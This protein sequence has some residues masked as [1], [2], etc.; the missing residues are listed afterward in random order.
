M[1]VSSSSAIACNNLSFSWPDGT[2]VLKGLNAAF[3]PGRTGLIGV[4]G[5]G[6]STLLRLIA[7]QLAP[8]SGSVTVSG[9]IGYLAQ[10]LTLD[11][12]ITVAALLGIAGR[13]DAIWAIENGDVRTATFDAVG[14]DW[15]IEDRA[16]AELD[17]LGL[18]R[19]RLDDTVATLSGG[20]AIMTALT[21]L[22]LRRPEVLLLDEPTNNL[23]ARA[24]RRLYAAVES[25]PGVMMIVSHDRELLGRVDQIADLFGGELR[26]YGGTLTDY[27]ARRAAEQAAAEQA[28]TTAAAQVRREKRDFTEALTKQA[29]RDRQGRQVAASGSLPHAVIDSHRKHAQESAGKSRELHQ[30]RIEAAQ[31]RLREAEDAVRDDAEIRVDLPGT[32]VPAGRTL[33]TVTGLDAPWHPAAAFRE[34]DV[35]GEEDEPEVALAGLIVRGPERIALT[36]PNGAGKTTLLRA[37]TGQAALPGVEVRR[38]GAIGYLPQRLDILD[39]SLTVEQNVHAKAPAATPN[40]VRAGLARFLFRG[41]RADQVAG[42]LS[43]GERF[44]AVLAALLLAQPPPQLLILDEPTNNL[45]MSSVRQLT[46]ALQCHRGALL[47][48]SHD[49]PFLNTLGITRWLWLDRAGRLADAEPALSGVTRRPRPR[50]GRGR[51][52]ARARRRRAPSPGQPT[53]RRGRRA[54]RRGWPW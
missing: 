51:R 29:R 23:D 35:A 14:D 50:R 26:M 48:V 46:E 52:R 8:A 22:L 45:D 15:D 6:K 27:E 5:A 21:A 30:E 10:D 38:G 32:A 28:V 54:G 33:L 40:E 36:G 17:R 11:T 43:G 4:N 2:V 19:V 31:T 20:E 1:P 44:R 13:L 53:T 12:S 34:P 25:W 3:S 42:G 39:E 9:E 47:V 7:G 49:Q 18:S 37:I 16:R 41:A 24:R